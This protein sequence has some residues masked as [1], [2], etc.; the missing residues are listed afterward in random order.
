MQWLRDDLGLISDSADSER[1]AAQL[2]DNG[3]VYLVPAFTGLG[4]QH[5]DANARGTITGLTRAAKADHIVRAG[6][7]AAAYQTHDLLEAFAADGAEVGL[8]RVEGG[9]A[10]NDWLLQFIADIC[11]R[12]VER[13]DFMEMT[14]LGAAALSGMQLGWVD[15]AEWANR[16]APGTRFEPNMERGTRDTLLAGW[17]KALSQT[18]IESRFF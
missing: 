14:A 6:L 10:A 5:W 16:K 2:A 3:G 12:P 15:A 4:A 17:R 18:L 1:R 11:D 13:P 9:M 8:L 7:E